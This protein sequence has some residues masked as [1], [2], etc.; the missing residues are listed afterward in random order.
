[1]QS[2]LVKWIYSIPITQKT[3]SPKMNF[4]G[5]EPQ[6]KETN[7]FSHMCFVVPLCLGKKQFEV[8]QSKLGFQATYNELLAPN[9]AHVA[10]HAIIDHNFCS[11]TI[12]SIFLSF[13]FIFLSFWLKK[14][15]THFYQLQQM[16]YKPTQSFPVHFLTKAT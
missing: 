2:N 11:A 9:Q 6:R 10:H 3:N 4:V 7:Y 13:P 1:M 5:L 15:Y 14:E 8:V 16:I 12:F